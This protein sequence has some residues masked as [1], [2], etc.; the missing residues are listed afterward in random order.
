MDEEVNQV[1][2]HIIDLGQV[3]KAIQDYVYKELPAPTENTEEGAVH[4]QIN[5]RSL[6]LL[7]TQKE[8]SPQDQ[9]LSKWKG[10]YKVI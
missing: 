1:L 10:P 6:V 4:S 2:R 7:K 9:L 3:Q 8:E 5:T